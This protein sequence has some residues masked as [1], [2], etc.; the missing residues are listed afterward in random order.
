MN[1]H[2][3]AVDLPQGFCRFGQAHCDITPPVGIYHR[4][5][6]AALHDRSEGVHRPLTATA[7]VFQAAGEQAGPSAE[8]VVLSVD[9]CL[10]RKREMDDLIGAVCAPSRLNQPDAAPVPPLE[11]QQIL[12]AF[13]HTHGAGLMDRERGHLPGGEFIGPY[14]DDMNRKLSDLVATARRSCQPASLTFATSRCAL[15]AHRDL[16]DTARGQIVCGYN[17]AGPADDTL[18]VARVSDESN[19]TLATIVNYACH[20]TTLAWENR[21]ISPD[22][23][24]AMREL[25]EQSTGAP[26]VF[27][28]G[29]SG[30]LGPVEGFVGD[31]AVADRNGRQLGH[32][33]LSIL[34]TL[35]HP[36]TRFQYSGP[37][38]SGATIGR[39]KHVPLGEDE[40]ASKSRWRFKSTSVRL[41]YRTDLPTVEEARAERDRYAAE[42][43]TAREAGD[44]LKARDCRAMV[45]RRHR[46]LLW[47]DNRPK[48]E[49]FALP[50]T[51]WQTGDAIWLA[52]E[53][54]HYQILQ[55]SLRERFPGTPI[56]VMTLVNGSRVSYLPPRE[57]YGKGIYQESIAVLAPG[58]LETLIEAAAEQIADWL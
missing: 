56:V 39:W 36:F 19:K 16:P 13:S 22:F 10:L 29:A 49:S 34:E 9:H 14:L 8:V 18:L 6:G 42:E 35:P 43:V 3:P 23:P 38:I 46:Q 37:V 1:N 53:S 47:L 31:P 58:C 11:R 12:V 27:L 17:P 48:E 2:L 52:V 45:E 57:S 32:A 54:E 28:Q 20:P 7:L 5:W 30:D 55:R 33:V 25:V 15:A 26:C 24:G 41:S 40:R 51:I 21:L 44:V 50:L 4:M